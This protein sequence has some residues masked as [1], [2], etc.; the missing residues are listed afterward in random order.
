M[1]HQNYKFL[2]VQM[3]LLFLVL[4]GCT[5]SKSESIILVKDTVHKTLKDSSSIKSTAIDTSNQKTIEQHTS[6]VWLRIVLSEQQ[7]YLYE[8]TANIFTNYYSF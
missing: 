5:N 2:Y 1:S 6:K 3:S 7:L 4:L 8:N